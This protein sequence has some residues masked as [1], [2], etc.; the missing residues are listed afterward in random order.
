MKRIRP[1]EHYRAMWFEHDEPVIVDHAGRM[2][3]IDCP[4]IQH[5]RYM[6]TEPKGFWWRIKRL[7][8]RW[9]VRR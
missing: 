2:H 3:R 7:F 1:C 8:H 5:F 4:D 6:P 9:T